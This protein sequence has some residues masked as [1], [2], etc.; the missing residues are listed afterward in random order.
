MPNTSFIDFFFLV[1]NKFRGNLL[2]NLSQNFHDRLIIQ[3]RSMYFMFFDIMAICIFKRMIVALTR[4]E[5]NF[6]RCGASRRAMIQL[7]SHGVK[8]KLHTWRIFDS[9]WICVTLILCNFSF[10]QCRL[11][12]FP[13]L[14]ERLI[15]CSIIG[16]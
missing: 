8:T 1:K 9:S 10:S 13:Q 3:G 14:F 6:V 11:E 15:P 7:E 16:V 4:C 5:G 12:N 2:W